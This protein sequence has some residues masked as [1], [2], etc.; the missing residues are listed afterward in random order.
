MKKTDMIDHILRD[1]DTE[2]PSDRKQFRHL[3]NKVRKGKWKEAKKALR[4]MDT[5]NREAISNE[6]YNEINI[7]G[8]GSKRIVEAHVRLKDCKKVFK[9]GFPSGVVAMVTLEFPGDMTDDQI[10]MG[11]GC[12]DDKIIKQAVEVIYE[13][14]GKVKL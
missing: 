5:F 12:Q 4:E 3:A 6:V 10:A 14:K 1:L 8:A 11:V 13:D 2:S 7:R 9:E